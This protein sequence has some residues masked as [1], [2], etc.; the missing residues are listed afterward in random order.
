MENHSRD[1][2]DFEVKRANIRH[3]DVKAELFEKVHP[4]G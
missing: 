1:M 2:D 4:E 3:H